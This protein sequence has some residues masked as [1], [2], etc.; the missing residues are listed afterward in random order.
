MKALRSIVLVASLGLGCGAQAHSDPTPSATPP[1]ALVSAA[2]SSSGAASTAV[3]G[4]VSVAEPRVDPPLAR[5]AV[6]GPA[7]LARLPAEAAIVGWLRPASFDGIVAW[8]RD[9]SLVRGELKEELGFATAR[10]L[11]VALGVEPGAPVAFGVRSPDRKA[12]SKLLDAVGAAPNGAAVARAREQATPDALFVR[13]VAQPTARLDL[14]RWA[15]FVEP[16]AA[17]VQR[18]PEARECSGLSGDATAVILGSEWIGVLYASADRIELDLARGEDDSARSLRFLAAQRSAPRAA[19]RGRC[20]KLDPEAD[21]SLCVD[22]VQAAELG[23]STG[24]LTT[25]AAISG[26]DD[27][28]IRGDIA[29]EGKKES[30]RNVELVQ[31]RRTFVDDGTAS[32]TL[33]P[34]GFTAELSWALVKDGVAAGERL[35]AEKCF[36]PETLLPELTAHVTAGFGDPGAD[37]KD[38]RARFDHLREAGFG[39]WLVLFARTWPNFAKLAGLSRGIPAFVPIERACTRVPDGRLALRVSG[40]RVP[41]FDWLRAGPPRR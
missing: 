26:V 25:L 19:P 2:S 30:L 9:V 23:A 10:E 11:L 28:K 13:W 6:D 24:M 1:A 39:G 31:P 16:V 29:R 38:L 40:G 27:R 14:A 36:T 18:C 21:L 20:A 7:T 34:E 41:V 15:S 37:F 32:L 22:A 5:V 35:G 33:A 8:S 17:K 12:A 3:P 4:A